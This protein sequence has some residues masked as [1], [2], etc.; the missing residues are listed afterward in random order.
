MRYHVRGDQVSYGES[1]GILLLENFVPYVPGDTANATTY[2]DPVSFMRV[3]GL[4]GEPI[5]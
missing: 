1:I 2:R 4:A 3:P 5:F